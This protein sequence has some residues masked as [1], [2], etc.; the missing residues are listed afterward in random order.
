MDALAEDISK[1]TLLLK[2]EKGDKSS[3]SIKVQDIHRHNRGASELVIALI[4]T[5]KFI[6]I[7]T[8]RRNPTSIRAA[9]IVG[10]T[11]HSEATSLSPAMDRSPKSPESSGE[12]EE[13]GKADQDNV[14]RES[15]LDRDIAVQLAFTNA[16]KRK[17]AGDALFKQP[18]QGKCQGFPI[19]RLVNNQQEARLIPPV[20]P[21][22]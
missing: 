9:P 6:I 21:V 1:L 19:S 22:E 13:I 20:Y 3:R 4:T 17:A 10:R 8:A 2:K 5:T 11:N 7:R 16:T 15:Q 14:V 18:R 12:K